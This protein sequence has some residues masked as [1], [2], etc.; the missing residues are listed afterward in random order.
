MLLL[1]DVYEHNYVRGAIL[2]MSMGFFFKVHYLSRV[3][4][5]QIGSNNC[6]LMVSI[7]SIIAK[8]CQCHYTPYGTASKAAWPYV[9]E[10]SGYSTS[11]DT[12][13]LPVDTAMSAFPGSTS[14]CKLPGYN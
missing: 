11:S 8:R 12:W 7:R 13:S 14:L 10:V 4:L 9:T 2:M 1:G 6:V 3:S 5:K